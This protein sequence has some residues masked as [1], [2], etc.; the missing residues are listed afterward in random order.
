[1]SLHEEFESVLK[2]LSGHLSNKASAPLSYA[3]YSG[4]LSSAILTMAEGSE[5]PEKAEVLNILKRL[6]QKLDKSGSAW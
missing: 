6:L 5:T 3:Y 1:M 4:F 2:E